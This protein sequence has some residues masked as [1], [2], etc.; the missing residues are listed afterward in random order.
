MAELLPAWLGRGR[1]GGGL[2]RLGSETQ[3][4]SSSPKGLGHPRHSPPYWYQSEPV[5]GWFRE[6]SK[7]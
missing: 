1:G 2:L 3:A 6:L 7:M 5:A 4:P